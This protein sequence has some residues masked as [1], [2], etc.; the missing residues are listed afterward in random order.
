M[1]ETWF[2]IVN[3]WSKKIDYLHVHSLEFPAG[4]V[5]YLRPKETSET[6]TTRR[7][8]RL[9]ADLQKAPSW[10][11]NPYVMTLMAISTVNT[12]VKNISK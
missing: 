6:V 1:R 4:I 10:R 7:S 5:V 11:T 8:R 2:K 12:L 3:G 9:K